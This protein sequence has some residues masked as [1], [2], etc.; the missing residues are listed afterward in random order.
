MNQTNGD[1]SSSLQATY[2]VRNQEAVCD[3]W[4]MNQIYY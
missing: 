2:C 1:A 4:H 3:F